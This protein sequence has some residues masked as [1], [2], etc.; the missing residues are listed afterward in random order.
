MGIINKNKTLANGKILIVNFKRLDP[1]SFKPL[2]NLTKESI[3]K[4]SVL[5]ASDGKVYINS[6]KE[7]CDALATLFETLMSE[8]RYTLEQYQESLKEVFPHIKSFEEWVGM[9]GTPGERAQ[10]L[11][12]LSIPAEL[13]RRKIEK[14]YYSKIKPFRV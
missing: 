5:I 7:E 3:V 2:Y 1:N 12:M 8:S 13:Q 4:E 6:K 9:Q 11:V 10:A 14:A